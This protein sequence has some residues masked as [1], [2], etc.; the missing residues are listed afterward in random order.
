MINSDNKIKTLI[1]KYRVQYPYINIKEDRMDSF[2]LELY[3]NLPKDYLKA[4]QES[5]K[6]NFLESIR[7]HEL[8][9]VELKKYEQ[10]KYLYFKN[11]I[12]LNENLVQYLMANNDEKNKNKLM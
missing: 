12:F 10:N 6:N 1:N 5:D 3:D 11:C 8:Y 7:N 4:I 2:L 9:S